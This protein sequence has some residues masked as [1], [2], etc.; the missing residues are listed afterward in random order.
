MIESAHTLVDSNVLL[1]IAGEESQ[2]REWSREALT[3]A[4]VDGTVVIN[5]LVLAEISVRF[6]S[7]GQLEAFL[8]MQ[9]FE[10]ENLPWEAA[11]LAGKAFALYK[12]RGGTK[13]APMPDFY[14]GA[15]AAVRGY[16]LLTRDT[17]R[18]TSYFPKLDVIGPD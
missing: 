10:R 18:F 13:R 1:D 8:P 3:D 7:V 9:S 6:E 16:R 11:F 14:I 17:A 4:L 5:Q 2:W 12:R 15:H